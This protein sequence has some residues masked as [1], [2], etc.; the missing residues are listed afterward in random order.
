MNY[1]YAPL[2]DQNQVINL[3]A[4]DEYYRLLYAAL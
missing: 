3:Q 4:D 1:G 2:P